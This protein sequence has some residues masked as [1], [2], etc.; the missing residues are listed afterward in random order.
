MSLLTLASIAA[1]PFVDLWLRSA[2]VAPP[3][4]FWDYG[5]FGGALDRWRAGEALYPRNDAG[6][7]H[8]GYLYPP[9]V[10]TFF[11]PF[12][13]FGT[14][15]AL[16][17]N[18]TTL[19]LLWASVQALV[20]ALGYRLRW[21]ERGGLLWLLVGFQPLVLSL[22]LAQMAPL[23]ATLLCL[24]LVA[25]E[26]PRDRSLA[27]VFVS[28]VGLVKLS[29]APAGA[30]LLRDRRRFVGAVGLGLLFVGVNLALFGVGP[31]TTYVDVL[32]W[33]LS[34]GSGGRPPT[35]WLPPYYRPIHWLPWA[36][37]LRLLAS[38][39]VAGIAGLT[40]WGSDRAVFALGV[41]AFPLLTPLP[42]T[43][44]FVALIP[45]SL[46]LLADELRADGL[47]ALPVVGLVFVH[48]H[49]YGT[50]LLATDLPELVPAMELL[51]PYYLL[52]PGLWGNV[53]LFG[54][55]LGAVLRDVPSGT[56]E[57]VRRRIPA[58]G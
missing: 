33:G 8:G 23:M 4:E 48:L 3:F 18:V 9:A 47:P 11:L 32:Q 1:W 42:Y 19:L 16:V 38:G 35:L 40:D 44:Y 20:G 14:D 49:A 24:G 22:K 54:T 31:S 13:P 21:W 36:M 39:L 57:R 29:Y 10:L 50:R 55:A 52:Q 17:W 12:E 27:G 34:R 15:A 6:G 37:G 28:L 53:L 41:T 46:A 58:G 51:A 56:V 30:Y 2:G 7:F 43:Y 45:A 26:R 5:A 25:G